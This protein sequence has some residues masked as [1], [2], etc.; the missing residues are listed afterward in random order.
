[1]TNLHKPENTKKT[2]KAHP[3]LGKADEAEAFEAGWKAAEQNQYIVDLFDCK[4][5]WHYEETVWATDL[6]EAKQKAYRD[7]ADKTT[8]IKNVTR[9]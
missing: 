9:A 1:M 7:F 8:K 5:Q 2:N 3:S 4:N 6:E